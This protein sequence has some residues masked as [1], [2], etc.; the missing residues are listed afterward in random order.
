MEVAR[1]HGQGD[2]TLE[3]LEAMVRAAIQAVS[4]ERIDRRLH[5]GMAAA[6]A[7][8]TRV[9]LA[10][11]VVAGT[12]ALVRQHRQGDDL[13]YRICT[14]TRAS[15]RIGGNGSQRVR[16]A[17]PP[18][19]APVITTNPSNLA[20]E[21]TGVG[22][23]FSYALLDRTGER[24]LAELRSLQDCCLKLELQTVPGVAE[25]ATVGG[26]VRQYQVVVDPE[27]LRASGIPKV[28]LT[29]AIREANREVGG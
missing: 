20:P 17:K 3:T 4:L 1:E 18:T 11:E 23:A 16:V 8:K 13:G 14:P 25:V 26:M 24:D 22:W 12:L 6:Q 15:L 5:G 28:H 21:A 9:V 7:L 10:L 19:Q 27:K 29:Q 2:V